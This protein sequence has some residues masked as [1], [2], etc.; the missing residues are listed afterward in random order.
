MNKISS[1][2]K[3]YPG[4]CDFVYRRLPRKGKKCKAFGWTDES[5][6]RCQ[7]HRSNLV[8]KWNSKRFNEEAKDF[9]NFVEKGKGSPCTSQQKRILRILFEKM[10]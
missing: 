2:P 6:F 1:D 4:N 3:K 8:K 5:G 7:K 9:I 10:A